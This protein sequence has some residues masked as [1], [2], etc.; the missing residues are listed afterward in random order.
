LVDGE[1][2]TVERRHCTIALDGER[3]FSVTPSQQLEVVL[4]RDGPP[5]VQVDAALHE[6]ASRGLFRV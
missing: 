4:Q 6:A 2:V 5:V 3:S 1:R